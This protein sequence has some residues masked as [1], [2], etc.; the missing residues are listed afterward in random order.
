MTQESPSN[1]RTRRKYLATLAGTGTVALVAGCSGGDGGDGGS[2]GGDS[3]SDGGDGSSDGGSDGGD[4]GSDGGDGGSDGGDGGKTTTSG[5]QEYHIGISDLVSNSAPMTAIDTGG[6]WMTEDLGHRVTLRQADGT[7]EQQIN[8]ARSLLNQGVDALIF[9]WGAD[10]GKQVAEEADIPVFGSAIPTNSEALGLYTGLRQR[11]YART[12]TEEL[13]NEVRDQS[14]SPP[15]RLLEIGFDQTNTNALLRHQHFTERVEESDDFEV[16]N[17]ILISGI[18]QNDAQQKATASLQSD[19]DID[20]VFTA[21]NLGAFAAINALDQ[22]DMKKTEDE[23]GHVP[24]VTI[25]GG[26]D[27]YEF[28]KQGYIDKAVDQPMM[29]YTALTVKFLIDYLDSGMDDA[30]LPEIGSQITTDDIKLSELGG[31]HQGV[32][33]WKGELWAP[34]DVIEYTTPDGDNLGFPMINLSFPIVDSENVDNPAL[35]GNV[36]PQIM[37]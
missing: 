33:P 31:N 2:D 34:A 9:T 16:A 21:W 4:G 36:I 6:V 7:K 30:S 5:E 19:Q 18:S 20:G 17:S 22:F 8:Q 29:S 32:N 12:A 15:Y 11:N 14:G 24:L 3:G 37:G 13:M 35:W 23:D 10:V 28:I 1:Y 25:D 26:P 27:V